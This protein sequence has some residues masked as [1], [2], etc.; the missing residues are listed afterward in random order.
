M[1]ILCVV[2]LRI[3]GLDFSDLGLIGTVRHLL[4]E[5]GQY[6]IRKSVSVWKNLLI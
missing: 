3:L 1:Q 2:D 6:S 4:L 5:I